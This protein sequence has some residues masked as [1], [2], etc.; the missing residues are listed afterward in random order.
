[1]NINKINNLNFGKVIVKTDKMGYMAQELAR[2][3]ETEIDYS[4]SIS[5]LGDFGVDVVI[6]ADKKSPNDKINFYL[7]NKEVQS[8]IARTKKGKIFKS[9]KKLNLSKVFSR[10]KSEKYKYS[11]NSDKFIEH[12]DQLVNDIK[13]AGILI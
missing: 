4:D 11:T 9:G 2:Q 10:N 13:A 5:K 3:L 6:I 7:R 1:M 8:E 12:A